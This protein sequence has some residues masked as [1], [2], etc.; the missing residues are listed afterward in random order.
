MFRARS[1]RRS[2][3][4]GFGKLAGVG[5]LLLLTGGPSVFAESDDAG[6]RRFWLLERQRSQPK[7][8]DQ[9][10]ARQQSTR[11]GHHLPAPQGRPAVA[12]SDLSHP[13]DSANLPPETHVEASFFVA[14]LGDS[15]AQMLFQGL[16]EEFADHP[17]VGLLKKAR[18]SS[19]L[20][21]DDYYDWPKA[22]RELLASN[23][24][25]SMAVMMVGSND[26]QP[27]KDAEGT[28]DPLTPK[29]R[30]L[31]SKRVEDIAQQFK[32]K[33][34]P[35]VWVGLPAMRNDK[36]S[37]D[38]ISFNGIYRDVAEKMG[39]SYADTWEAF[40][41]DRGQYDA[42]GPDM[43]GQ[44]VKLRAGD[45]VHFTKAG[46]RK[47]AHFAEQDIRRVLDASRPAGTEMATTS[48]AVTPSPVPAPAGDMDIN[49]RIRRQILGDR[50]DVDVQA[51]LPVPAPPAEINIPVK[52][53]AGPVLPL[54]TA[55]GSPGGQLAVRERSKAAGLSEVQALLERTFVQGRPT[56]SKPGRSD[57]FVWPRR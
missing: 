44:I 30:E 5:L 19:G 46:A 47:L 57:D 51:G 42:Y 31:Y 39:Q 14:I 18:E 54:T 34:I 23:E 29:W 16:Q 52:P 26:R 32:D 37:S 28:Y 35:L 27:L 6:S 50:S 21:R 11:M 15:L 43:S 45:G 33:R 55:M 40:V 3:A 2:T 41:D 10:I 49:E 17:E 22:V 8:V 56:E 13:G 36:L 24:R 1:F 4:E 7:I 20:V 38:I 12:G 9:P 48:E 53:P 25:I